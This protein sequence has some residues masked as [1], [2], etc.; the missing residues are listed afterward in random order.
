VQ[1][2]LT[3]ARDCLLQLQSGSGQI[4]A[5]WGT[6]VCSGVPALKINPAIRDKIVDYI[7][8]HFGDFLSIH[9]IYK[10]A[11]VEAVDAEIHIILSEG[12]SE[13]YLQ[14]VRLK[15]QDGYRVIRQMDKRGGSN[16]IFLVISKPRLHK[17]GLS[18]VQLRNGQIETTD[19]FK[20]IIG[21]SKRVLRICSPFIERNVADQE[22]F[23][24]FERMIANAMRRGVNIKILSR[25]LSEKRESEAHWLLEIAHSIG[26]KNRISIMDYHYRFPDNSIQSSTH[27]KMLIADHEVAYIGSGELRKNSL[28]VNFEVGCQLKG[29]IVVGAVE[30][31]DSMFERGT[32]FE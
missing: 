32:P 17:Y 23:P 27:A 25:E 10:N 31:F 9:E 8:L 22:S 21:S 16:E 5:C 3:L 6:E 4:D 19:C 11:P 28:V 2:V 30:I 18:D 14:R 13:G 7:N 24:D 29:P 15:D 1:R 20:N 12:V 26:E